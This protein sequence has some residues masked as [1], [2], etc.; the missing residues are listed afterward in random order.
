MNYE[1]KCLSEALQNNKFALKNFKQ[2]PLDYLKK[3]GITIQ[4]LTVDDLAEDRPEYTKCR[5]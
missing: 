1:T 3:Q 5:I 2:N 4:Y